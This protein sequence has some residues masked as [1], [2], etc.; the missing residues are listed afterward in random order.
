MIMCVNVC[1]GTASA[2][3]WNTANITLASSNSTSGLDNND[4]TEHGDVG[5][6]DPECVDADTVIQIDP[7][8]QEIIG[9]MLH[10]L[11]NILW[12]TILSK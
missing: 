6:N 12:H 1:V 3:D 4:V 7:K 11:D 9:K 8:L 5:I 10:S 2:A